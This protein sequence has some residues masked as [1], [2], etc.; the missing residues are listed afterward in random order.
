MSPSASPRLD[1]EVLKQFRIIIKSVRRHFQTIESACGI[2]GAQL[3]ALAKI[4]EDPGITVSQLAQEM[5]IHQ[6]TAS[7]LVEKLVEKQ[8]VCKRRLAEDQRSVLL[9]LSEGGRKVLG[10]AP[11]PFQGLLPDVLGKTP[12][13][14]LRMLH[15]LLGKLLARMDDLE[16]DAANVHLSENE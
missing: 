13:G 5:A 14:E 1:I 11:Q 2:S 10:A 4:G 7:N 6:S 8:L 15:E 16:S 3:W 12:Y 9:D